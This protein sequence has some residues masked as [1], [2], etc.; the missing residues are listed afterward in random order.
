[1]FLKINLRIVYFI[2][3]SILTNLWTLPFLFFLIEMNRYEYSSI[4]EW[5]VRMFRTNKQ[6]LFYWHDGTTDE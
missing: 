4:K 6:K 1:M 2:I 3:R 5:L